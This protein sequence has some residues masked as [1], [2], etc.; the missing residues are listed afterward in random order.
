[1]TVMRVAALLA[2][3]GLAGAQGESDVAVACRLLC[4]FRSQAAAQPPSA[5]TG[6]GGVSC[7]KA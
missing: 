7:Q 2:G 4:A 3:L 1:M 5:P 6:T